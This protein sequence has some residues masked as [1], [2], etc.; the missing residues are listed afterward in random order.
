M[1]IA[2][3]GAG[4]IGGMVAVRLALSGQTVTVVD[5]GAHLEAI[6]ANGLRL[7][8]HDGREEHVRNVSAVASCSEAGKQDLVFLAL[9]AYVL[10]AVA[11]EMP[12]L[13]GHDPIV[14]P[15]QNGLPW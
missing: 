8:H 11:P 15:L 9:K 13:F 4:A 12:A 2:V 14:V 3:I 6:R 7:L 5:Q 10:E 1:R